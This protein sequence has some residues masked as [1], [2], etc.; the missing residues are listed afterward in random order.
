MADDGDALSVRAARCERSEDVEG[1][2]PLHGVVVAALDYTVHAS[3]GTKELK[4][5]SSSH[6][7]KKADYVQFKLR[8]KIKQF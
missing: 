2:S 5:T 8:N 1:E 3:P 6:T 7:S 4:L